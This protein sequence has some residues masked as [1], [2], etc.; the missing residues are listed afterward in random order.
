MNLKKL[1]VIVQDREAQCAA[2]DGSQRAG[3]D[4]VTEQQQKGDPR[5]LAHP[6]PPCGL[7]TWQ[8]TH[9]LLR[10]LGS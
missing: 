8:R 7:S 1:W 6:F 5:A 4:W 3:H 9:V 2:A 10:H